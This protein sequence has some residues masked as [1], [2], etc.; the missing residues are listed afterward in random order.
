MESKEIEEAVRKLI[1]SEDNNKEISVEMLRL[2]KKKIEFYQHY[3]TYND[4]LFRMS[5]SLT[6]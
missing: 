2:C 6:Q 3:D 1:R 5:Y 4:E